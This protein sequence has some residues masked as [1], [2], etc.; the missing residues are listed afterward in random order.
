MVTIRFPADRGGEVNLIKLGWRAFVFLSLFFAQGVAQATSFMQVQPL[1]KSQQWHEALQTLLSL[2]DES[3]SVEDQGLKYFALGVVAA[4][5][6]KWPQSKFYFN[7]SLK[8]NKRMEM[9]NHFELAKIYQANNEFHKAQSLLE[10]IVRGPANRYLINES[11][12]MLSEIYIKKS[13]WNAAFQNLSRL[14]RRSRGEDGHPL[15]IWRLIE[16]E[17]ERK[18]QW[19]ACRWARKL[20]AN[21]P[22]HPII[23][24]WGIDL[25]RNKVKGKNLGCLASEHD[26]NNR[27]RR[28]HWAGEPDRSRREL[29]VLKQN[30]KEGPV[31]EIDEIVAKNLIHE[32]F[33]GEAVETLLPYYEKRHKNFDYLMNLAQAAARSGEYQTAV[34]AYYKAHKLNPK[35]RQGRE[36]LFRAAFLSYQFQDYDGATR[37]FQE[38]IKLHSQ[39][40]LS[41]DAQWHLAWIR[42]LK[43][44]YQ[45]A[46]ANFTEI[47]ELKRKQ[48]RKWSKVP[49]E[50][51]RYW[52][53]MSYLRSEDLA[54]AR[55][56]LSELSQDRLMNFYSQAA[57]ARLVNIPIKETPTPIVQMGDS[58]VMRLP[59]SAFDDKEETSSSSSQEEAESE[60]NLKDY[61]EEVVE[62]DSDVLLDKE[63]SSVTFKDPRLR[64]NFERAQDFVRLGFFDSARWEYYEVERKTRNKDYLLLLMKAYEEIESYHRSSYIGQ[65]FFVTPRERYEMDNVKFLWRHTYPQAFKELVQK[66]SKNYSVPEEFIWSIIRA[67]SRY[68]PFVVSPVGAQGLMQIMPNTGRQVSRLLGESSF[69]TKQLKEPET[70]I[71]LGSR[72]L[73]RL[74]KKFDGSLPLVAASYNAGPHRVESWL[75][76][77]GNLDMDEFI[78]HIPFVE[79][80]N[81]VKKVTQYFGIYSK[82]YDKQMEKKTLTWLN[83]MVPVRLDRKPSLRE[84]WEEI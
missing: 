41:R 33:A 73:M 45:G 1:I 40:G 78:E 83:E 55:T 81:Y 79:T 72:Y 84:S 26:V 30:M 8:K 17:M 23:Y 64:E 50:K 70:N 13:E 62:V 66:Y 77:F 44:D 10:K 25:S 20:Y 21:Y 46:I 38:L 5:Q 43:G 15:V 71:R 52:L 22:A 76:A 51:I 2:K 61:E 56:L 35:S 28:W 12:L 3:L 59:A 6:Q 82:L 60:E 32:G 4:E 36:A 27:M 18:R 69:Q 67:E 42:Y 57:Q 16:V 53:A 9:H 54:M 74:L 58:L 68:R 65:I 47:L 63:V 31:Y 29:E 7:F 19:Q 11:Q 37:K 75:T 80:R 34:G 14:E 48:R 24:D 39:S 49:E